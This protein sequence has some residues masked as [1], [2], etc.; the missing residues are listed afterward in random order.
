MRRA[1]REATAYHEAGH[2]LVAFLVGAKVHKVTIVPGKGYGAMTHIS[3]P[4]AKCRHYDASPRTRDKV[5]RAIMISLAGHRTPDVST[6][7][8]PAVSRSERQEYRR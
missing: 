8:N 3:S 5:E 2:A 6:P 4:A 1:V 7:L